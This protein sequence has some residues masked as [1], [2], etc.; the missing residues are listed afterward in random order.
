MAQTAFYQEQIAF[1]L[2]NVFGGKNDYTF[3]CESKH[4]IDREFTI[5]KGSAVLNVTAVFGINTSYAEQ[6]PRKFYTFTATA[7][8]RNEVLDTTDKANDVIEWTFR[9]AG[10]ILMG[11][12]FAVLLLL[13]GGHVGLHL[14]TVAF[15]IGSGAGGF[16]GHLIAR[17]IY[18][19]VET[20]L[21]AKGEITEVETE[22]ATL[23][24]TLDMVFNSQ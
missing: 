9:V 4:D 8:R 15:G 21:E 23:T 16:V 17:K 24:D 20:R 11:S 14:I 5:R 10:G 12:V 3:A 18:H 2:S 7:R 6:P 19:T 1:Y 13:F 22:W